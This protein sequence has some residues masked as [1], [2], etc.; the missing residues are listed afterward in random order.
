[1]TSQ[2]S[3]LLISELGHAD[4]ANAV[5]SFKA[6]IE[7]RAAGFSV[8]AHRAACRGHAWKDG[9]EIVLRAAAADIPRCQDG[10][11]DLTVFRRVNAFDDPRDV[12]GIQIARAIGLRRRG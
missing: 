7:I 10:I 11:I 1:M 6:I 9:N 8:L 2:R 12:E 5:C 3:I 4:P